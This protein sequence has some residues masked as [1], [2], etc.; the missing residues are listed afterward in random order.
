MSSGNIADP[1]R[2]YIDRAVVAGILHGPLE[3]KSGPRRGILLGGVMSFMNECAE[4]A[5]RFDQGCRTGHDGFEHHDADRKIW[6][7]HDSNT[8]CGPRLTNGGF[9]P[10]TTRRPIHMFP[11]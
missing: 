1:R 2:R 6:R 3:E 9:V 11:P 4:L 7:R 10:R 5:L 8:C